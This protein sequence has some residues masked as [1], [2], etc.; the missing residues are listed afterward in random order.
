MAAERQRSCP[1]GLSPCHAD[2]LFRPSTL[3]QHKKH[4]KHSGKDKK[5]DREQERLVKEAKKFLKKREQRQHSRGF[6]SGCVC[7]AGTV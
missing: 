5:R 7:R 4:K 2:N 3:L 1:A 6:L